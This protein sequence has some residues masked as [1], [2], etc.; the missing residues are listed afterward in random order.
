MSVSSLLS[1]N[2]PTWTNIN[3]ASVTSA[4]TVAVGNLTQASVDALSPVSGDIVYNRDLGIF[5]GFTD[6]DGGSWGPLAT[7]EGTTGSFSLTFSGTVAGSTTVT[8]KYSKINGVVTLQFPDLIFIK[9]NGS[10]SQ[11]VSGVIPADLRP[12]SGSGYLM[13]LTSLQ[14]QPLTAVC[15]GIIAYDF[16][17]TCIRLMKN[18]PYTSFGQAVSPNNIQV[19][20]TALTYLL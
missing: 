2:P 5:Q 12:A 1:S 16:S 9:N 19:S 11:L 6:A 20:A 4:S 17:G 14:D 13:Q 10:A 7:A 8:I 15:F 18:D 3:C